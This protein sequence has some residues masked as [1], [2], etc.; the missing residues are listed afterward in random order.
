M[1]VLKERE[2]NTVGSSDWHIILPM[3][4]LRWY[5]AK[6]E[7]SSNVPRLLY[8]QETF[9]LYIAWAYARKQATFSQFK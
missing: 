2:V 1:K 5:I 9:S 4:K 7:V 3:F 6:L 8:F